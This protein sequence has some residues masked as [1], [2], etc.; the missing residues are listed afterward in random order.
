MRQALDEYA[1]TAFALLIEA[2]KL[3]I[4]EKR[5]QLI[6]AVYPK[7]EKEDKDAIW[8]SL[9]LPEDFLQSILEEESIKDDINTLKEAL[10]NGN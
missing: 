7:L 9:Q 4:Y 3:D 6:T 10:E 2:N 5:W 8:E 1:K